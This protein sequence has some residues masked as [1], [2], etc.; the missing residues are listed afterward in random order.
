METTS[1]WQEALQMMNNL[2]THTSDRVTAE[3]HTSDWVTAETH[4]SDRVTAEELTRSEL[5][6]QLVATIGPRLATRV[7]SSVGVARGGDSA[8]GA[9]DVHSLLVQ[10][11]HIHSQQKWVTAE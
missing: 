7:I 1:E 10:L 8:K 9:V 2:T 5:V 3:T 11:A 6:R 4:T